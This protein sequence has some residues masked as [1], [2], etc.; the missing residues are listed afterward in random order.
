MCTGGKEGVRVGGGEVVGIGG[1]A[2]DRYKGLLCV[3]VCL[4]VGELV[5]V[6]VFFCDFFKKSETVCAQEKLGRVEKQKTREKVVQ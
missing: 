2:L 4:R 5:R 3:C 1:C 6:K